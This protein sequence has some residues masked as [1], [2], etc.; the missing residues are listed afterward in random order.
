M[1]VS[2]GEG[3][4]SGVVVA[5]GSGVVVVGVGM[6]RFSVRGRFRRCGEGSV[7]VKGL[8]RVSRSRAK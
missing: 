1:G 7:V 3:A 5:A 2:A 8:G 6:G 4:G